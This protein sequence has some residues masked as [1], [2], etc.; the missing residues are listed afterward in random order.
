MVVLK[1]QRNK[2]KVHFGIIDGRLSPQDRGGRT[3]ICKYEGRVVLRGDIVKDDSGAYAV[4]TEQSSSASQMTAT[5]VMEFIARLPDSDGQ[6]ADAVSAYTEDAPKLLRI[7]KSEC[8]DRWI[9]NPR[10]R[11][12]KSWSN[13]GKLL[14]FFQNEICT[15]IQL[16]DYCGRDCSKNMLLKLE[17]EKV[18]NGE[19]RLVHRKH[20]LFLSLYVNDI[21]MAGTKQHIAPMRKQLL[22]G[23]DLDEFASFLDHVYLGCT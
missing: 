18:P 23:V 16:L 10:H 1:A 8:P 12:P 6:A 14:W 20:G 17:W 2:N 9:R 4:F 21:N 15:D 5:Q 19:C 3:K 7:P 22:K 13:I 11:W